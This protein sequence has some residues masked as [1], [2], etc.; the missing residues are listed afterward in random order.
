MAYLLVTATNIPNLQPSI[1]DGYRKSIYPPSSLFCIGIHDFIMDINRQKTILAFYRLEKTAYFFLTPLGSDLFPVLYIFSN[2]SFFLCL[3]RDFFLQVVFYITLFFVDDIMGLRKTSMIFLNNS[4]FFSVPFHLKCIC[5]VSY[6]SKCF[7]LWKAAPIKVPNGQI[8]VN[9]LFHLYKINLN[10]L[11]FLVPQQL[12]F[13]GFVTNT[14][15]FSRLKFTIRLPNT[16]YRISCFAKKT[17]LLFIETQRKFVIG[18]G[19][20]SPNGSL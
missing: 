10:W 11:W 17:L 9:A 12:R 2:F 20:S 15:S 16:G 6:A 1:S 4:W 5:S 7:K 14:F 8:L 19:T 3:T 18:C 13:F